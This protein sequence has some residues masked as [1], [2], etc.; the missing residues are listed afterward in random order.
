MCSDSQRTNASSFW[1]ASS[2]IGTGDD[3]G[4]RYAFR[5]PPLDVGGWPLLA[6]W[7]LPRSRPRCGGYRVLK[8]VKETIV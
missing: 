6:A 2:E 7:T 8:A 3:G 5:A 1:N 4:V